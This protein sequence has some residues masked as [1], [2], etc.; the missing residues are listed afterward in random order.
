MEKRNDFGPAAIVFA[1]GLA[2]AAMLWAVKPS[3]S[4][5]LDGGT[6]LK[7]AIALPGD[8]GT[9]VVAT[10]IPARPCVGPTCLLPWK[11]G[12]AMG[13]KPG[14]DEPPVLMTYGVVQQ[15]FKTEAECRGKKGLGDPRLKKINSTFQAKMSQKLGL[16][17]EAIVI[18]MDCLDSTKIPPPPS[19]K[20]E[21]KLAPGEERI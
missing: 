4:A 9:K 14:P 12:I 6:V 19:K 11:I 1:L 17:P 8:G 5:E 20:P 13:L 21:P 3:H 16:P 18:F 10:E 15:G 7:Y 2:I